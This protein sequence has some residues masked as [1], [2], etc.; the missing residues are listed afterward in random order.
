MTGYDGSV[1]IESGSCIEP[2]SCGDLGRTGGPGKLT[3]L[4]F[5]LT[6]STITNLYI[7]HS[8]NVHSAATVGKRSC[9]R[10]GSCYRAGKH[11]L[12]SYIRVYFL[13]SSISNHQS[14]LTYL[15]GYGSDSDVTIES[16]SCIEDE[17]CYG[18]GAGGSGKL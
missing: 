1:T 12:Y 8:C 4:V 17:S 10:I 3:R 5:Y 18:L 13:T 2:A 9:V 11:R 6:L 14:C 7:I 16:E 15:T